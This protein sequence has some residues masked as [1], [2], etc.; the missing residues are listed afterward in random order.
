MDVDLGAKPVAT[1]SRGKK[2]IE[3]R[4]RAKKS[5]IVFPKYKDRVGRKK[6]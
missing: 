6:K 5:S 2:G 1:K 4:R 3:K